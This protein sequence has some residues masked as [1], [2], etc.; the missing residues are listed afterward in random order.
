[1]SEK[2]LDILREMT[3]STASMVIPGSQRGRYARTPDFASADHRST[4]PRTDRGM[5]FHF[6]HKTISKGSGDHSLDPRN[7]THASA[8]QGYIERPS[9]TEEMDEVTRDILRDPRLADDGITPNPAARLADGFS[10]PD[11]LVAAARVSFGTLGATQAERKRFWTEVEMTEGRRGR[12]Q[13][14]IIAELP[15]ELSTAERASLARDFCQIFEERHLPYWATVHSPGRRNDPRNFHLH[16]AYYDRPCGR[17][18]DGNWD[19][20]VR[21]TR[22]K[23]NRHR[24]VSRP[25][26]NAK[27]PD[28]RKR[29]WPKTLRIEFSDISNYYLALSGAEKRHDPR[30][31]RDAHLDK[32]PTEHLGTKAAALETIGLETVAGQRNAKREIRWKIRRAEQP[33]TERS[34]RVLESEL[35]AAP[36]MAAA[37]TRLLEIASG[38]ITL[39]R[40]SVSYAIAGELLT[41]RTTRRLDFLK[42]ETQRLR[43]KDDMSDRAEREEILAN[44]ENELGMI[45]D[46]KPLIERNAAACS[47]HA[48]SLKQ[49]SV[50]EGER[51]DHL[52]ESSDVSRFLSDFTENGFSALEIESEDPSETP[53]Q[54]TGV[55]P[56]TCPDLD[57][58]GSLDDIDSLFGSDLAALDGEDREKVLAER[59]RRTRNSRDPIMAAIES[60]GSD[61]TEG[62]L[63]ESPLDKKN[64]PE[65]FPDAWRI[66]ASPSEDELLR[67]DR[68]LA[69]LDNRSLRHAAIATRDASDLSPAGNFRDDT[70]RAWAVLQYES[71][72][73][74]LDLD[75][76]QH[77]PER[78]T[79]PERAALHRDESPCPIRVVRKNIAR[80]RVRG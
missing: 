21:M 1:M 50:E 23:K 59:R 62:P 76:G 66:Q 64:L 16:I 72:R 19:F 8:H 15:V 77:H 13:G 47:R 30:S 68:S 75:T 26:R 70:A 17:R 49:R 6:S 37:R 20:E 9:A 41:Y 48:E 22:R 45:E 42:K 10:Y 74:G 78:A 63:P 73:R 46:R 43:S 4:R 31:Y 57:L 71:R 32:E 60:L 65:S 67:I 54:T 24:V 34:R 12:V 52:F 11:R 27:H 2:S 28:T 18:D 58:S 7:I 79:D 53:E 36:E 5:T 44:L 14:R 61:A 33:W 35:L 51:F 80:Q 29:S 40:T 38:G 69:E 55:A 39:A 3:E 25:F 56:D